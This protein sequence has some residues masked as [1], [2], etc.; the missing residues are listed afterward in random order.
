MTRFSF[1][2]SL[3]GTDGV[4]I[5][6]S[7]QQFEQ[8]VGSSG[9]AQV[10]AELRKLTT[11]RKLAKEAGTWDDN[12]E[13]RYHSAKSRIKK[14]LPVFCFLATFGGEKRLAKYAQP[15][16]LAMLDLDHVEQPEALWQHIRTK[17]I[18]AGCCLAHITPSCEGLRL[19]FLRPQGM[20][21]STGMAWFAGMIGVSEYDTQVKDLSRASFAVPADYILYRNDD[22]LFD[23][24][25]VATAGNSSVEPDATPDGNQATLCAHEH[26]YKGVPYSTIVSVLMS[27]LGYSNEPEVGE[28]NNAYFT[29]ATYLR[30]ICDFSEEQL[31]QVIPAF[32]L[33]EDERRSTLR[34]AIARPRKSYIPREVTIAITRA[35]QEYSALQ[36]ATAAKANELPLPKLPKVLRILCNRLP[37]NYHAAM[38]MAALPAAGAV[39]TGV[40]FRYIDQQEQSL[41]FFSCISAPAASGKSFIRKPIELLL[42]PINEADEIEWKK[43]HDY[44]EARKACKNK[45]EQPQDPHACPRNIGVTVSNAQLLQSLQ[46]AQGKHLFGMS[47]EVDTLVKMQKAGAWGDL[48]DVLRKQFDNAEQSQMYK[49]E[50]SFRGK[51]KVFYNILL[52][53]TPN[54]LRR[55]FPDSEDGLVTRVCFASLPDTSFQDIPVFQDYTDGERAEVIDVMRRLDRLSGN[56]R[57]IAVEKAIK[58]WLQQKLAMASAADS[59]AMDMLRKRSAVIGF[60]A[61]MLAYVMEDCRAN[62]CVSEMATWVAEYTFRTQMELFGEKIEQ[63][64]NAY[65]ERAGYGTSKSLIDRLPDEFTTDQLIQARS[66]SHQS[67]TYAAISS[68]LS[69]WRKEQLIEKIAD[70]RYRKI[71]LFCSS[72]S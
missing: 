15:S 35:E 10:C 11:A 51:V 6:C 41:S 47:E 26:M 49:S 39:A 7:K 17:A 32:G 64:Q 18:A 34:S 3:V 59:K 58:E 54:S 62:A 1:L 8:V 48:S 14:Q 70:N 68:V 24:T 31:L 29:L 2:P 46:D 45:K 9:T 16:G 65:G 22:I 30:Y 21:V 42:T 63:E 44:D 57:C 43:L 72:V 37:E 20:S 71:G 19:V 25:A 53:G 55:M 27:N 66:L 67:T 40:R 23:R 4:P 5:D 50:N 13:K 56:F 60:R 69:R 12:Q 36:K 28:R 38:I 33:P 52:T 61:G